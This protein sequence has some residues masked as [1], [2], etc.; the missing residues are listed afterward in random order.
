LFKQSLEG[1]NVDGSHDKISSN[2]YNLKQKYDVYYYCECIKIKK[3]K[4]K[5]E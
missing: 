4:N 3:D 2:K 5:E 1:K